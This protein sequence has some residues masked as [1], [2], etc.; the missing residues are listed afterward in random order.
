MILL[1]NVFKGASQITR[2]ASP[3]EIYISGDWYFDGYAVHRGIF[4]SSDNGEHIEVRYQNIVNPPADE[5]E[6]SPLNCDATPGVMY[7]YGFYPDYDLWVSFD[8]GMNWNFIEHHSAYTK[9]FSGVIPGTI[10]KRNDEGLFKSIDF[11]FSFE[12]LPITVTCYLTEEVGFTENEFFGIYGE[13]GIYFNLVHTL[14]YG[15]TYTDIPIDTTIAFWEIGGKYPVISRGMEPGELYL[16][17]WWP[18]SNYKI[19]HSDD[20]GYTWTQQYVSEEID[21]YWWG[22]QYT[23]GRALGSFYAIRGI[24]DPTLTHMWFYIYYSSDYGQTFTIYFHDMDTT[25]GINETYPNNY[26]VKA[27]PNPFNQSTSIEFRLPESHFDARL[28]IFSIHGDL[29][30]EYNLIGKDKVVWNATD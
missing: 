24:M 22:V 6:V 7:N 19:F 9:Y 16:V 3:G 8:Y 15:Q 5:M 29:I 4:R 21:L 25:V 11:G 23:A 27:F 28:Q 18:L 20:T 14:D 26:S 10:F 12:L 2:G 30:K 1:F 17:S 13:P